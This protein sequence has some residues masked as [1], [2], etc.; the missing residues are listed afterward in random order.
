MSDNS[1]SH[2]RPRVWLITGCTSGFGKLFVSAIVARGDKVIA[3]AR[4]V[5]A[6]D[7]FRDTPNVRLLNLDVTATQDELNATAAT[8]VELFGGVDVLVN[9]AGYVL[10]GAWEELT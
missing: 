7:E 2:N 9:N 1:S 6:L 8:A 4:N 10:S 5:S 3:T